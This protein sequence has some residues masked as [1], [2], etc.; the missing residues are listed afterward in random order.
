MSITLKFK[1][2]SIYYNFNMILKNGNSL[3][4]H[5][6]FYKKKERRRKNNTVTPLTV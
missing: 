5:V 4:K 1:S 6:I 2:K 3:L